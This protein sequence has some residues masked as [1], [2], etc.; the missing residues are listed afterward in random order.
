MNIN[1]EVVEVGSGTRYGD[2]LVPTCVKKGDIVLVPQYGGTEVKLKEGSVFFIGIQDLIL[3]M[4][5]FV[6]LL[7]FF[8][9][10]GNK[11]KEIKNV[12]KTLNL[13]S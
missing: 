11:N 10:K 9:K 6:F 3:L 13:I 5:N 2:K 4:S 1:G 7:F 8:V 12:V